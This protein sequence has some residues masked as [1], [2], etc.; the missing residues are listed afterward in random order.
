M[1]TNLKLFF[2]GIFI[3]MSFFSFS[4][5]WSKIKIDP[6]KEKQFEPYV[7]FRHGGGSVYQ[8]WKTNNKFQYVKEMWYYS[9]SFY[10]KRNHTTS[11]ETMN[12]AAID[13]SR[14][15]SNRKA[16]EESIVVIPGFKDAIVLLPTNKL[17]YKP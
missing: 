12:E 5:D 4:Q 16:T 13:I 17:I 8:T 6:A 2:L 9:E 3:T 11:G 7:E 15:E 14:F 10:I 1:K